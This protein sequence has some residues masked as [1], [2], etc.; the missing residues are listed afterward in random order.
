M[1]FEFKMDSEGQLTL[2]SAVYQALGAASACWDNLE[3][4]GEFQSDRCKEVGDKLLALIRGRA[5]NAV[6]L[7]I[8]VAKD[9]L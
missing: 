8:D 6:R 1:T 9:M 4:A 7:A 3:G 5:N 2:D